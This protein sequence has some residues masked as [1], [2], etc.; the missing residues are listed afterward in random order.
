MGINSTYDTSKDF[1]NGINVTKNNKLFRCTCINKNFSRMQVVQNINSNVVQCVIVV[2]DGSLIEVG[3]YI[4]LPIYKDVLRVENIT[5]ESDAALFRRRID[6]D[7]FKG[8][9]Q[10]A[11]S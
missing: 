3:D 9:L 1:M 6:I 2:R 10:V 5:F 11:L 8:T 7:N 4:K